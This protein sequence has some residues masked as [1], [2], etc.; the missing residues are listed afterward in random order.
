M[1]N[2]FN[3]E[4]FWDTVRHLSQNNKVFVSEEAAPEDFEIVWS[5]T[6]ERKVGDNKKI[7]IEGLFKLKS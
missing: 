3:Y 5:K 1:G 4:K 6:V 2:P 7:A